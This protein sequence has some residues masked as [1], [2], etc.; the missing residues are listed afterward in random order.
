M[1]EDRSGAFDRLGQRDLLDLRPA[2]PA[3]NLC[4]KAEQL[5]SI[6]EHNGAIDRSQAGDGRYGRAECLPPYAPLRFIGSFLAQLGELEERRRDRIGDGLHDGFLP[7]LAASRN[8]E[9]RSTSAMRAHGDRQLHHCVHR[10]NPGGR[11]VEPEQRCQQGR[12]PGLMGGAHI[13]HLDLIALEHCNVDK[14]TRFLATMMLH[15]EQARRRHFEHE[16]QDRNGAGCPP[17]TQLVAVAPDTQMNPR[18]LDGR[19]HSRKG[20]RT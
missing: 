14:F 15:H 12:A 20:F 11:R 2:L 7:R 8:D 6:G 16:A 3:S 13:H 4:T 10:A 19:G 1:H 18:A 9:Q 17:Y 5:V